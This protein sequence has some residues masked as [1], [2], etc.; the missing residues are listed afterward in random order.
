MIN[1]KVITIVE[2]M[3]DDCIIIQTAN[4][5]YEHVFVFA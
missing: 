2:C 1:I 4:K 5:G 3:L